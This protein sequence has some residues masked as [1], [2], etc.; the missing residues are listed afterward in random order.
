MVPIHQNFLRGLRGGPA[1]ETTGEDNLKTTQLVH[2]AYESAAQ[3]R[4]VLLDGL[5]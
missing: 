4:V 3:N 2:A 5:D 1:P